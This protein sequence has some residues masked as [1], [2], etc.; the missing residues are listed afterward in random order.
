MTQ[1]RTQ[2]SGSP[3]TVYIV[4]GARSPFLKVRGRPGPFTAADLAVYSARPLLLKQPFGADALDEVVAG[5]VGPGPDEMNIARIISLRIGCGAKV[6]AWTVQRNCASGLQALDCACRNIARGDTDLA[7]AGGV[8]VMSHVPLLL[9][10]AMVHWLADWRSARRLGERLKALGRLRPSMLV[11]VV[12]LLKGLKDPVA[13]LSMGQTAEILA[14]E[15]GISRDRMDAYALA[16]HRRLSRA[17]KAGHLEEIE[18]IYTISGRH[19]AH[20]DGLRSD[21][22]LERL[23]ALKPV[24]DRPYGQ[25]TAGNSAQVSDGAAWLVLASETA[26]ERHGLEPLARIIDSH[27]AGVDP[28]RMGLGPV[29]ATVPLLMRHGLSAQRIDYWE[30]N[31]AFAAQVLA[32]LE[33]FRDPQYCNR[34]FGLDQALGEIPQERLNV[35]GGAISLGHPVGASGARIALHLAR[36]LRRERARLGVAALCIGGGQ[37]GAMLIENMQG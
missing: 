16:S 29:H 8:E 10:Q 23:A 31:E 14:F 21:T 19:Y 26:L 12:G 34:E 9:G 2:S 3:R 4:D 11:P 24:F 30:I 7:L 28:Q 15:F 17:Q 33:A 22:S 27:W 32:C 6:P 25:V 5:C 18:A 37:G 20:D 13:G 1:I 35:D 36:V